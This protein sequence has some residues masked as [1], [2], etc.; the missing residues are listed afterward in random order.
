MKSS[1]ALSLR[2]FLSSTLLLGVGSV[3]HALRVIVLSL[4][5]SNYQFGA[6]STVLLISTLFAEFGTLGLSQL[7][8][9]Q[10]LYT[11]RVV[12]RNSLIISRFA[13]SGLFVITMMAFVVSAIISAMASFRF[14]ALFP[15]L[16]CAATNVMVLASLRASDS[17]F[18]HPLGYAIKAIIVLTDIFVLGFGYFEVD[19]IMLWGEILAAPVLLIFAARSGIVRVRKSIFRHVFAHLKKHIRTASWAVLSSMSALLLLNQE[20]LAA[21]LFLDLEQ[22]GIISKV[23]LIK[24][25]GGQSAFIFGTY[26]HRHIVGSDATARAWIFAEIRRYEVYVYFILL[27]ACAIG[28]VPVMLIYAAVYQIELSYVASFSA[29]ALAIVFFFNPFAI[30]LQA[31]GRFDTLTQCNAITVVLFFAL[32]SVNLDGLNIVN[33]SAV[34]ALMWFALIRH[35]AGKQFP[36]KH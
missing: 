32:A 13:M 20:R 31:S 18:T 34:T 24:I 8:Y 4:L 1:R 29:I 5:L 15:T 9:N 28:S 30:F 25:I 27:G 19:S 26:F 12:N 35:R 16:L 21:A 7:V 33:A 6:V 3:I 14:F 17:K 36:S 10:S 23:V 11:P 22:M 2:S